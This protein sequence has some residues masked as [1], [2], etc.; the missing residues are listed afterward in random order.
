MEDGVPTYTVDEA[1]VSM[2]FG[3]FQAFVL[4]YSGMAKISEAMEMMLL[5]FVGQSVQAEWGLSAQEESLITSVVFLGMLVGAYCWG[6]VSDNYGRRVGFNFTALVTGGAGLLSAFAPNYSSLIVLR[7]LVGVGLG[8]GPVLSSWFLEFVPAPNRGTWMVIFSAFWTIGT[9]MEASL[10]WAVMPAFGWRWLLALSSLP[11]FA[12]LLFYPLTL[13][14]PRYLCMK[15]RIADALH[16]METMA[17]VNRVALPSGRLA[18]GHRMELHEIADSSE[19]SQMVSARKTNSV[20]HASK[21]GIGG[22]NAILRLLSPNL[23]R[24]T[25]LLWTVFLGLAFLYYGLVLLTSELSHGNR[26]CGSE[27][28]ETAVETAHTIDVNLYRNVF[29]TSFGE[30]PGLILS[31]AIVDKFG[32]KLSMS[33]MLY[34]SCLCIA[35]LMFPQTEFLTT[36]FLF[37]A[38]ICISASFIVLHIYAPEIYPTAVR[39]TGVGF[40]SSIARFGGILCPL[41]AVGLVHACH[42]TAAIM[43]FITVMLVSAIAVSYFPLETSGRKLSDHIAS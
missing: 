25:L 22:L 31:A 42:Q 21:P 27:G 16:V 38:R 20:E 29:I 17:R 11:S 41:V 12:L 37:G 7:F 9:I 26:I 35:P 28:A 39:A 18:S 34:I 30:V 8:G 10:A 3:K 43:V 4:A 13:E 1:L 14:S 24:S 19:S 23:I 36:V 40:A 2:G 6:L 15:G 32:R 33:S 5:S